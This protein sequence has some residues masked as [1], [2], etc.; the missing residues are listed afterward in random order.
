[1]VVQVETRALFELAKAF[2]ESG[3]RFAV[4]VAV[5]GVV[6]ATEAARL[7]MR[8]CLKLRWPRSTISNEV[9]STVG[10]TGESVIG[11]VTVRHAVP[12]KM[13]NML[14]TLVFGK[15][16]PPHVFP[17]RTKDQGPYVMTVGKGGKP[18]TYK[19]G[20]RKGQGPPVFISGRMFHPGYRGQ[21]CGT[22]AR[23]KGEK[24]MLT[25]ITKGVNLLI[26]KLATGK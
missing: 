16:V 25:R 20:R 21:D 13:P 7:T 26:R 18:K 9:S 10:G 23:V 4:D 2:G 14:D 12:D 11:I 24:V 3:E 1:M 19:S 6:E 5:A 8:D 22:P 15:D 17:A